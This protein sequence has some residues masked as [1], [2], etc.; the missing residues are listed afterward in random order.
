MFDV[1]IEINLSLISLLRG[2]YSFMPNE[3]NLADFIF[4]KTYKKILVD[5]SKIS[6]MDQGKNIEAKKEINR[7]MFAK[8]EMVSREQ[9]IFEMDD[10]VHQ[11]RDLCL[12]KCLVKYFKNFLIFGK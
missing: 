1:D 3:E 2:G 7:E 8:I 5:L 6:F 4:L 12:M 11:I 10:K 9:N